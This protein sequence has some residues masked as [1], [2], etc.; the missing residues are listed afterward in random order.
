MKIDA[1]NLHVRG[2]RKHKDCDWYDENDFECTN[3][4]EFKDPEGCAF[5]ECYA[6]KW[7]VFKEAN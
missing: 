1:D 4:G 5:V 7:S 2:D 6:P 3:W